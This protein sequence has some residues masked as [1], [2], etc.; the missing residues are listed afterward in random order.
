VS[1][2]AQ[3]FERVRL[4]SIG[5]GKPVLYVSI[6]PCEECK[7]DNYAEVKKAAPYLAETVISGGE[8]Y[9]DILYYGYGYIICNDEEELMRLYT[10]T[11]GKNGSTS[12]NKYNGPSS[13]YA[14]TS[15]G[16]ENC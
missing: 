5:A 14:L 3:L 16:F 9:W 13:V 12:T 11:V 7:K 4:I 8:K 15:T 1:Y 10:S 6:C 2:T